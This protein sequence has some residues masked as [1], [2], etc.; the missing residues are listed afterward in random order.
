MID[1]WT[2][3]KVAPVRPLPLG[4]PYPKSARYADVIKALAQARQQTA[5]NRE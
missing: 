4:R 3:E 2:I 5:T 1:L